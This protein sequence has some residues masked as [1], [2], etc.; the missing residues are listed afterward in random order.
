MDISRISCVDEP[1]RVR[2]ATLLSVSAAPP[3][4]G[5]S[6]FLNASANALAGAFSFYRYIPDFATAIPKNCYPPRRVR[7]VQART[8]RLHFPPMTTSETTPLESVRETMGF[9]SRAVARAIGLD[10]SGFLRIERGTYTPRRDIADRI[11]RFYRGVV[12]LGMIFDPTHPTYR[13]WLN[14][15]RRKEIEKVAAELAYKHEELRASARRAT[16]RRT[17]RRPAGVD[18]R[19]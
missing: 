8:E 6:P 4:I 19:Q 13:R 14:R 17:S 16:T 12:P 2:V 1:T 7:L 3:W 15:E 5:S 9:T 10:P 18:A 11:F